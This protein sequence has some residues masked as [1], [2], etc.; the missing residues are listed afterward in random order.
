MRAA[1]LIALFAAVLAGPG[2]LAQT[3]PADDAQALARRARRLQIDG[4]L[5]E[6]RALYERALRQDPALFDAQLGLGIVLDLV[7]RYDEARTHFAKAI[8]SAPEGAKD[9]ALTAM[10]VSYAFQSDA[11]SAAKY[12]QQEYD[13]QETAGNLQG[14]SET[15]NAL[16]R[17][18]LESGDP[19]EAYTWYET[20]Y[21]TARRQPNLPANERD[22]AELRWAHARARIAARRGRAAEA[23]AQ[24][25]AVK[26]L[27][28]KG[29]NADQAI[30]LPYLA[31]YV[32]FHL[33]RYR[34]AVTELQQADQKDP[35]ILVMLAQA[36]ERLGDAPRAR[37]LYE[38]VA[39]STAHSINNAFARPIAQ[40]KLR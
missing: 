5:D 24:E 12:F 6:S 10:G 38:R 2:A 13:R 32:D 16:G 1:A 7:G 29:D 3:A 18:Y 23:H 30:Q 8:E 25:A 14:A 4:G 17:V 11:R 20:G 26:A 40:K 15:A 31:G 39:G 34:N 37:A 21:E 27:V 33:K 36:Y 28:A 22:L 19:K 9:Q 35:F